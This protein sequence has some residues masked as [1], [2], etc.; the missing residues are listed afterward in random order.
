MWLIP[1]Q[2]VLVSVLPFPRGR[3]RVRP[4]GSTPVVKRA[5]LTESSLYYM[6]QAFF[7]LNQFCYVGGQG[8]PSLQ[9]IRHPSMQ[10]RVMLIG[11]DIDVVCP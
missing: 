11:E 6:L 5:T 8:H 2:G 3:R 10:H 1:D 4:I 7:K 9:V